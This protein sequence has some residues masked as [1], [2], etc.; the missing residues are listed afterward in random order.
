MIRSEHLFCLVASIAASCTSAPPAGDDAPATAPTDALREW[1]ALEYGMFIHYGL[2]TFVGD[3]F[4]RFEKPSTDYAP[5]GLDVDGW[6]ET[7]QAAGMKYAV[8]TVKHHYGHALWPT[9]VSDYDVTTSSDPTDVVALFVE[10]CR[11]YGVKPGFYYSLGWDRVHMQPRTPG[12]YEAFV[13]A[14]LTELLTRYGPIT[15]LWF[16]IPWDL[17]PDTK[18]ALARLY[19]HCKALQPDCLVL[20]NQGFV[21]GSAIERRLPTYIGQPAGEAPVALWPKDLN[22][23]ER[24][25]P[26][27]S[28]HDPWI[29]HEGVRCYV[30]D[31]VCDSLGQERWFWGAND[32]VRPVRQMVE[33]YRR[34]VGRGANLLLNVGPDPN[35]QVPAAQRAV[36]LEL[37][38]LIAHPER[39]EDSL[40]VGRPAYTSNV[41]R[42][43]TERYGPERAIDLDIGAEGGTRWATDDELRSAW[44]EVD[45]GGVERFDHATLCE[46]GDSIRAWELQ[47]PDG[48]GGWRAVYR[49]TKIGGD[50]LRVHFHATE[51]ARVRLAIL[52]ATIGPTIWDFALYPQRPEE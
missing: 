30:P 4:G 3:Q 15:E 14:Q 20:Y 11:K 37:A 52:D 22:C 48:D 26:L 13:L 47:V 24:V 35:G 38:E 17:G 29:E 50:G 39:V 12:E 40:L 46:Y 25:E 21:D 45:L 49:G 51:A 27:E 8:L 6:I 42:G 23:G 31:E 41:Y 28:G 18:G 36:L 43:L 32:A 10:A 9:E 19:A 7:A 5:T 44:L 2:S 34:S 1:E 33:L 16:D